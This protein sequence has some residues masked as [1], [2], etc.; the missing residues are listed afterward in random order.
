MD[1]KT[2][3][4]ALHAALL[5][6]MLTAVLQPFVFQPAYAIAAQNGDGS[7]AVM[8]IAAGQNHSLAL[9]PDGTVVAW[10][11]NDSGQANVPAGLSGV[12]SIAAGINHSLALKSDG[13]VVVWGNNELGQTNVPADLNGVVSIAAGNSHSLALKSDGTVVAWGSNGYSQTDVPSDLNGVVSIAAGWGHSLALKSDGTVVAWG[14]NDFRQSSVPPGL[15]GVVAVD[16]G[17]YHS[18]ALKSDGTVVSWGAAAT[19]PSGLNGVVSVATGWTH[20]LALKSDG[21]VIGWGNNGAGQSNAPAA[22]NGV[23][24]I[25]AGS[26]HSLALKSDGTV[27]AWGGNSEGQTNV[28]ADLTAPVKGIAVAAGEHHSLALKS[29]GTVVAWGLNSLGQTDVPAGLNGVV[30]I[31]AGAHFS[32]ALEA[33]GTI[34]AWGDNQFGQTDVP[35]GLN[36]VTAIAAGNNH[37]L[38]LKSGG[39]VVAWGKND[40]GQTNVPAGLNGVVAIAAGNDHSL[41]LKAD[42]TVVAWGWNS[43]GQTNVPAG[44]NGVKSIGAGADYSL[45]LKTDGTVI[46]W[47]GNA[48][49]QTSAPPGLNGVAAIA[50]RSFHSLA[51]K[52]DGTLVAWGYND[53][54]QNEIP[55]DLDQ[56]AAIATGTYHTLALKSDG[57]V[58]AWGNVAFGKTYVPESDLRDIQMQDNEG[59]EL[60]F[61]FNPNGT[62]YIVAVDGSATEVRIQAG[63]DRP[64]YA[65][66]YTGGKKQLSAS[67][68]IVIPL[69]GDSTV[70]PVRVSPYLRADK[71]YTITVIRAPEIT[72]D[73]DGGEEWKQTAVT[74][75]S[76]EHPGNFAL[77]YAWSATDQIPGA[78]AEWK[79]FHSGETLSM[80]EGEGDWYLHIRAVHS[81]AGTVDKRTERFRL[82]Y[83]PP[84]VTV[85]MTLEDGSPYADGMWINQ[86]V[87]VTAE[88]SDAL[89]GLASLQVSSDGGQTWQE[90]ISG[91]GIIIR[92]DGVHHLQFRAI[93]RAGNEKVERRTVKISANGLAMTTVLQQ[94]DGTPYISG[95]WT[96]EPVIANVEAYNSDGAA[97]TSVTYSF[98]F[99]V[100]WNTYTEPVFFT[101]DGQ[102]DVWFQAEDEAD[103]RLTEKVSIRLDQAAPHADF[104]PDGND[105]LSSAA[106]TIVT[107]NDAGAGVDESS[108]RYIWS[109]SEAT[110]EEEEEWKLFRS[111]DTLTM[112]NAEGRWYLHIRASDRAG[113]RIETHSRPFRLDNP[114]NHNARLSKL[115]ID[116]TPVQGFD[117]N[118]AVYTVYVGNT[119]SSVTISPMA[120]VQTA[121]VSM[122]IN[123]GEY[124]AVPGGTGK[125]LAL[126]QGMNVAEIQ[127]LARD[128]VTQNKYILNIIR[129]EPPSYG[130]GSGGVYHA[131]Q[132][133]KSGDAGLS[134][135]I[136]SHGRL[137]P[138]FSPNIL[139][140]T[141]RVENQIDRLTVKAMPAHSKATIQL[142]GTTTDGGKESDPI[143]LHV[144][145]N[146]IEIAVTAEDGTKKTYVVTVIRTDPEKPGC[147]PESHRLADLVGHW[148][149]ST[150]RKA[151]CAGMVKGYP[152]GSFKP[153]QPVTRAEFTLMLMDALT[154]QGRIAELGVGAPSNP[155]SFKDQEKIGAWAQQEIAQAVASGIV[156]G[157]DDGTFRPDAPIIRAEMASMIARALQFTVETDALTGFADDHVIPEWAKGAAEALRQIGIVEGRGGN[158]FVPDGMATRAEAVVMLWRMVD[159]E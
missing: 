42:G 68:G 113:N 14:N 77:N 73:P 143:M 103:N 45:A 158:K 127:V 111:G 145:D 109:A 120:E 63:L 40:L 144:G 28:P 58:A 2:M 123:D 13:T 81:E 85:R 128:G 75:V 136:L 105:T 35:A 76:V 46:A 57:S 121:A 157:Y 135:L 125:S 15:N 106:S 133:A 94:A 99:G 11:Q 122:R 72:F 148:A 36:G 131:A 124:A 54:G 129:A 49:G 53:A 139:Q 67:E 10:G 25:A 41:A 155:G 59:T 138:E 6:V 142:N 8:T 44:L 82:D 86:A 104:S 88:A 4:R 91:S 60:P 65:D 90:D 154:Q 137:A 31:A 80:A 102:Y 153:D 24:S 146:R 70:I 112:T 56:V 3:R 22:L 100:T 78:Q 87:H 18:L 5:A 7:R 33:G 79:T 61:I 32:L 147:H 117:P 89:S 151:A 9:K 21:T 159:R 156:Q 152:D 12:V 110:P 30:S 69:T 101:A 52:A 84:Q 114:A 19:A 20:S 130:G 37:S 92:S 51:L 1:R 39:T 50:A 98:D 95:E 62:E 149:D 134:G 43:L 29:D 107:V 118:V 141:V 74:K 47:G 34:V 150:M 16:A 17:I 27:V 108:L 55:S 97:V 116:G 64:E 119:T 48:Y 23:I 83:T 38:A 140:Y 132:P 66:V 115:L 71:T 126:R 93:D 26:G 96:R